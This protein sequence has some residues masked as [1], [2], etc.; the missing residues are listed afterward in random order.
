MSL[1]VGSAAP[2]R[3]ASG[4]AYDV[5]VAWYLMPENYYLDADL[6]VAVTLTDPVECLFLSDDECHE[7]TKDDREAGLFLGVGAGREWWVSD[8]W[9]LG[10]GVRLTGG[11]SPDATMLN[12][13]LALTATYN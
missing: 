9:A 12:V 13:L 5:N 11:F 3:G 2:L 4:F 10:A 1:G 6:G 8:K 7:K